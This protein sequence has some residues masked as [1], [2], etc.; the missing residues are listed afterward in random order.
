VI[1]VTA[2][3]H[4]RMGIVFTVVMNWIRLFN[5]AVATAVAR[6]SLSSNRKPDYI[7]I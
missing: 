3:I 7:H 1:G 2:T 4:R 6:N 5:I